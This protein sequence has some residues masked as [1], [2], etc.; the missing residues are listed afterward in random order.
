MRERENSAF[1][2]RAKSFGVSVCQEADR[3]P[4]TWSSETIARQLIRSSL[5]VSANLRA[6]LRARSNA[7]MASKMGI[8]LEEADESEHW[9]SVAVDLG[10]CSQDQVAALRDECDQIIRMLVASIVRVKALK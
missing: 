8:A 10:H 5:S 6:S 1:I 3:W 9:L 7:E 4:R 2:V